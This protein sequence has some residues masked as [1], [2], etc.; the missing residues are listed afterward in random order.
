M[1]IRF[2]TQELFSI[3]RKS[4]S[5]FIFLLVIYFLSLVIFSAAI[6]SYS[7]IS[8]LLDETFSASYMKVFIEDDA[9]ERMVSLVRKC[10]EESPVVERVELITKEKAR[11][12][13]KS[14]FP[15]YS[16]LLELFPGSPFPQNLEIKF[17][18]RALGVG[19]ID[20]FMGFLS[21]FP[22]VSNVQHNYTSAIQLYRIR[23]SLYGIWAILFLTFMVLYIPLN[24]SFMRSIF[25]R[26]KKL[27]YLVEYFGSSRRKL[28]ATF[29]LAMAI[30][31][32]LVSALT[33][34]V[35]RNLGELLKIPIYPVVYLL[36]FFLFLQMI[37]SFDVLE[38]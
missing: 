22:V 2:Y 19:Y 24:L 29:V 25:E 16:A 5:D 4:R 7:Y 36:L 32:L 13:F 28:E 18:S 38:K 1:N 35:F 15:R 30:P 9:D 31:L 8:K 10:A 20:E 12:E 34:V 3:M 17:S 37:F 33:L 26:E 14:R 27:F 21:N 6:Q 23:K 11:D